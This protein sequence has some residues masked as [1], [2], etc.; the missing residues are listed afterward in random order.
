MTA[1]AVRMADG[2]LSGGVAIPDARTSWS[3]AAAFDAMAVRRADRQPGGRART[4]ELARSNRSC[5]FPTNRSS[6][7]ERIPD[8]LFAKSYNFHAPELLT[9]SLSSSSAKSVAAS[10]H[11]ATDV[12]LVIPRP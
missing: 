12:I 2:D 1:A 10:C 6:Y 3:L 11:K 8:L 5:A 7:N 9:P 4:D